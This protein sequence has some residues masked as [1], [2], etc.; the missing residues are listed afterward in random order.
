MGNLMKVIRNQDQDAHKVSIYFSGKSEYKSKTGGLISI[1]YF[2][3]ML[4][5][6]YFKASDLF[7]KNHINLKTEIVK[8]DFSILEVAPETMRFQIQVATARKVVTIDNLL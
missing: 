2:L 1:L 7:N 5:I 3:I 4:V 8:N 6:V